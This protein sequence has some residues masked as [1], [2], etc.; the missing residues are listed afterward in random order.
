MKTIK[1]VY[2]TAILPALAVLPERMNSR[3]AIVMMLAIGLQ[4]SRLIHRRQIPVAHARGLW[5]FERGGGV[6]GVLNH[7]TTSKT[8]RNLC[9]GL[10][11]TD[12]L[13]TVYEELEFSDTLAAIFA[14]LLLWTD[15]RSLPEI[16]D[17]NGS[18]DLY[19]RTW[20][21]GKPHRKTWDAYYKSATEFV[22]NYT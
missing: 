10:I 13:Q 14:R 11:G 3:E 19:M 4:E 8:S 22:V 2:E 5:Q 9:I 21:A 12:K 1:E 17:K 18:W 7:R 15:P 6:R 16:G 20:R